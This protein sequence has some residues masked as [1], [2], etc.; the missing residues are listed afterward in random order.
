MNA[1]YCL[2]SLLWLLMLGTTGRAQDECLTDFYWL[3][4]KIEKDYPGYRLKSAAREGELAALKRDLTQRIQQRPDSCATYL[5]RYVSWFGDHHLSLSRSRPATVGSAAVAEEAPPVEDL[6][7]LVTV[8]QSLEGVW[9]GF[10]GDIGI[11]KATES[12]YKVV[13]VSLKNRVA[14][15]L[16]YHIHYDAQRGYEIREGTE[17]R[18]VTLKL[19]GQVLEMAGVGYFVKTTGDDFRDKILLYT[20]LPEYTSGLNT[21]ALALPL[22]ETTFYLRIPSFADETAATLYEK[23]K[24]AILERPNLILDIRNNGGGQDE[25]YAVL[26]D[27]LYTQPVEVAG[28]EWYASEGN[29]AYW[30]YLLAENLLKP[31]KEA[32]TKVFVERMKQRVGGYVLHPEDGHDSVLRKDSVFTYP[33]RIG[34]LINRHNASSAEQFLL[35]AMESKKVILFG[36]ENTSGTLD[37]SNCLFL[38]LPSGAYRLLFPFTRSRRLPERPIDETG[39]APDVH[40]PLEG[41]YQLYDRLDSWIYFVKNYLELLPQHEAAQK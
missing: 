29:I 34:I 38:D 27:L 23:N 31:G 7:T 40:I 4:D 15:Q 39:I 20:Y 2:L 1:K 8:P 28:V 19:A 10:G 3:V 37:Y 6:S 22:S 18:P 14:G 41:T 33:R 25:N 32:V 36:D 21:F 13:S 17:A 26:S 16:L 24:R 11:L 35:E 30:E 12:T 9:R 5:A